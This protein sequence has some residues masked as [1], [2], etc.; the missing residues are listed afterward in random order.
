M[1]QATLSSLPA[2]IQNDLADPVVKVRRQAMTRLCKD[3]SSQALPPLCGLLLT[4][5][6]VLVRAQAAQDLGKLKDK[7]A[8]GSL[9]Q[10]LQDTGPSV[11]TRALK[12]L[13]LLKDTSAIAPI[14]G[15]LTDTSETV[16]LAA[17][18]AL[19]ALRSPR[20]VPTL[21]VQL[22]QASGRT[23]FAV[24]SA[25][26]AIGDP[27]AVPN[28]LALL[29]PS[30]DINTLRRIMQALGRIGSETAIDRLVEFAEDWSTQEFLAYHAIITLGQIGGN[31]AL[32]ALLGL[33]QSTGDRNLHEMIFGALNSIKHVDGE[34]KAQATEILLQVI[35]AESLPVPA[36]AVRALIGTFKDERAV[37]PLL[38]LLQSAQMSDYR[39]R[40]SVIH[41][42]ALISGPVIISE[43]VRLYQQTQDTQLRA[44]ILLIWQDLKRFKAAENAE[45]LDILLKICREPGQK[46]CS[47]AA[48]ILSK[49]FKKE[50]QVIDLFL[51]LLQSGDPARVTTSAWAMGRMGE[52]RAVEPILNLLKQQG[53]N[54]CLVQ[55]LRSLKDRRVVEYLL[56]L[57][58]P[59][60]AT[61]DD[62]QCAYIQVLGDMGDTRAIDP[63]SAFLRFPDIHYQYV[64]GQALK[65]LRKEEMYSK[66]E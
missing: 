61:F 30:V 57:L 63:I 49:H 19:E 47:L 46:Q 23:F 36:L 58:H 56:P 31:R 54:Y 40:W 22:P 11:R 4:D 5:P 59:G 9:I 64:V 37:Q 32:S 44:G 66:S 21:L 1:T 27:G 55:A 33:Y 2:D 25:L 17:I 45:M 41:A 24:L 29:Q 13:G 53:Y 26:G 16:Q 42:L 10:S 8:V 39:L 43:T 7:G 6:K 60:S 35:A 28:L 65:K 14:M 51:E 18:Q 3:Y 34:L 48:T 62:K 20:A 38:V 50:E 52:K 15:L 12:A